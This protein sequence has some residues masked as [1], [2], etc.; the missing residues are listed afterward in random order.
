LRQVGLAGQVVSNSYWG[1]VAVLENGEK[2]Q[3]GNDQFDYLT[4]NLQN[5]SSLI[6]KG[7]VTN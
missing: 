5:P 2:V 6:Q 3:L 7:S 4:E 1:V